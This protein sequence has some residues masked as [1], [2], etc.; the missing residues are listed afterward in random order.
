MTPQELIETSLADL[1]PMLASAGRA[2]CVKEANDTS[3]VIELRGFCGDCACSATYMDG[4][5]ELLQEKMPQLKDIQF[6]QV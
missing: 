3:C 2:V 1:Q 5:Q 6:V 4:I